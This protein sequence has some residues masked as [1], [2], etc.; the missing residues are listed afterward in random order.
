[1]SFRVVRLQANLYTTTPRGPRS[2]LHRDDHRRVAATIPGGRECG[3]NTERRPRAEGRTTCSRRGRFPRP[4]AVVAEETRG[5]RCGSRRDVEAYWATLRARAAH[6]H[7]D[8]TTRRATSTARPASSSRSALRRHVF[9]VHGTLPRRSF[10][11]FP[12]PRAL[13]PSAFRRGIGLSTST[14]RVHLGIECNRTHGRMG[15]KRDLQSIVKP[16]ASMAST[17]LNPAANSAYRQRTT[18]GRPG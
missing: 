12:S 17:T 1:M 7:A 9:F 2:V 10:P 5:P 13:S 3:R 8:G 6:G 16:V 14:R 18:A 11:S 4:Y 15:I